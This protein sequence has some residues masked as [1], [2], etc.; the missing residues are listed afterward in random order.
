ME[1]HV[2]G[3]I[4]IVFLVSLCTLL[5]ISKL[6]RGKTFDEVLAEKRQ[7]SE[8]IYGLTGG[9]K[10][11]KKIVKKTKEKSKTYNKDNNKESELE[12]PVDSDAPSESNKSIDINNSPIHTTDKVHVEFTEEE[13]LTESNLIPNKVCLLRY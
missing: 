6:P 2:L 13:I 8:K 3:V 7:L 12:S 5:F 10:K 4:F 9:K 11:P 1:L